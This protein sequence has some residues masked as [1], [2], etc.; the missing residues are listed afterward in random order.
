MAKLTPSSRAPR[1]FG[2][3]LPS[4]HSNLGYNHSPGRFPHFFLCVYEALV[5]ALTLIRF[6]LFLYSDSDITTQV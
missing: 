1:I 2:T 4:C 3:T 5:T 6:S